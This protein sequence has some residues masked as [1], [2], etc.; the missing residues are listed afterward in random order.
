MSNPVL[1]STEAGKVDFSFSVDD[2]EATGIDVVDAP[3]D[4]IM[5]KLWEFHELVYRVLELFPTGEVGVTIMSPQG[6]SLRYIIKR[7]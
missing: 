5:G 1:Y 4:D 2:L 7:V 3:I 6:H